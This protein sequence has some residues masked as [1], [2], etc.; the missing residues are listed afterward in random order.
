MDRSQLHR[1]V[2]MCSD[3]RIYCV[4]GLGAAKIM[5]GI[6]AVL[7]LM[8]IAYVAMTGFPDE[9]R[10]ADVPNLVAMSK[11]QTPLWAV[12]IQMLVGVAGALV[13]GSLR[14]NTTT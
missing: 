10:T 5:A 6:I 14:K 13:G 12:F 3:R 7:N 2:Y 8:I 11:A 9:T 1:R 4:G